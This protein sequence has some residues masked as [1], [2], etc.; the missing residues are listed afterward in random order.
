[1]KAEEFIKV[2]NKYSRFILQRV[3]SPYEFE[4]NIHSE[5]PIIENNYFHFSYYSKIS[6]K[7]IYDITPVEETLSVPST[8]VGCD[9]EFFFTDKEGNVIPSSQIVEPNDEGV[10]VDGFQGELNPRSDSCRQRHAVQIAYGIDL[11]QRMAKDKGATVNL[12]KMGVEISDDV[13]K[14][15]PLSLRKFGCSPTLSAYDEN[16]KRVTGIR[17]RFR[18]GGGHIHLGFTGNRDSLKDIVKLMDITAGL[19]SVLIDRDPDNIRRRKNYGR[20]GEYRA[21]P[22]G[23]EYRVPSN[24]WL[25]HYVLMSLMFAQ[26]RLAYYLHYN[27][28]TK[29]ILALCPENLVR[30]AINENDFTLALEIFTKYMDWMEKKGLYTH[31]GINITNYTE[32]VDVLLNSDIY[33]EID[34]TTNTKCLA[35]WK[36]V[37]N[38]LGFGFETYITGR[39]TGFETGYKYNKIK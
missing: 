24:F 37:M 9:P 18:A 6:L 16:H 25:K 26:V 15:V 20:A 23:L 4:Y 17:E 7:D 39:Q 29:E 1:M 13:W 32:F 19:V 30:K 14:K 5:Y 2:K 10:I 21:K 31:S 11:A 34:A 33:K 36:E 27:K 22:Y 28:Y 8:Y 12:M 3:G 38:S 35:Q